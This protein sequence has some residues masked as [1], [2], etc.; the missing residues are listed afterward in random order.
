MELLPKD[1]RSKLPKLYE[2]D[3][4][5]DPMIYAKFFFPG[6]NW[7][8]FVSEGEMQGDDFTFFGFVIGFEEEWGYFS[9]RELQ[10]IEINGL[11]IERDL[12]FEQEPFNDCLA[13]WRSERFCLSEN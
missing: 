13:R 1:L 8:W 12:A 5:E 11:K 6:G 4:A 9:L 7:T 2:Q 10:E 3:E